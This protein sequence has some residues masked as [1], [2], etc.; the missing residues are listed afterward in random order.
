MSEPPLLV[1]PD[2]V[3][4]LVITKQ[5]LGGTKPPRSNSEAIVSVIRDLAYVQWDPVPTIA[6]SHLLSL[7]SRIDGFKPADLERLL[8]KERSVFEYWAP[9]ASLVLT[10]DYPLYHSLM[11]RYPD[12]LSDSWGNQRE[13]ARKFLASHAPLRRRLRAALKHGPLRVGDFEDHVRTQRKKEDWTAASDVSAMLLQMSMAGEVMVVG[14]A[15]NQNLWGLTEG[16]L[17]EWTERGNLSEEEASR[18]SATRAL[19]ALGTATPRE[20][21]YYF[22]RGRY[23][24][25]PGT[26]GDLESAGEIHRVQIEGSNVREERYVHDEDLRRLEGDRTSGWSARLSLVPPFDNLVYSQPRTQRLF[27][28]DYVREQFL[29]KEKRRYGTYVLPI[30]WGDRLIGRIDPRIDRT[31]NSLVVNAVHAE[32]GAPGDRDVADRIGET[33]AGL[34][35]F[36]GARTVRY[37]RRVPAVWRSLASSDRSL[38]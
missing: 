9:M 24:D 26:L 5:R 10:E 37:A 3:R 29:P 2:S 15:G 27:G 28:F 35:K 20:L 23:R 11:R 38:D 33:I 30:V 16:F 4:R 7:W 18:L 25:L 21:N 12:S 13:G 14:H 31:E 17:P 6:P 19:K 36:V 1:S 22:V 32:P 34:G 8:W